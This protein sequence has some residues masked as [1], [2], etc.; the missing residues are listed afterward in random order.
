MQGD[1]CTISYIDIF[2][3]EKLL[4]AIQWRSSREFA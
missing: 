1:T 4:E 3:I 2:D